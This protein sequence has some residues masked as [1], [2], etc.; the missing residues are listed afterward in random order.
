MESET[1]NTRQTSDDLN[2]LELPDTKYIVQAILCGGHLVMA[3]AFPGSLYV[4]SIIVGLCYGAQWTLMPAIT[5]EIFG[6]SHFG[7][8]FNTLGVA[9]PVGA[10]VLSVKVAGYLYDIEA[11]KEHDVHQMERRVIIMGI[12]DPGPLLCHGAH[13][14][15][16]TFIILACVCLFGCFISWF[17]L[18]RTRHLYHHIHQKLQSGNHV[19]SLP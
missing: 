15:C 8:L 2:P 1:Q 6:F 3:S 13:C 10:Y 19:Q 11:K 12:G 14:F 17:L 16:L 9:S 7:T 5:S 18:I 4:G